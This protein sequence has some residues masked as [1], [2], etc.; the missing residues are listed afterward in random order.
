MGKLFGTFAKAR[1]ILEL[2]A[3]NIIN[4]ARIT[5]SATQRAEKKFTAKRKRESFWPPKT[6]PSRLLQSKSEGAIVT[7]VHGSKSSGPINQIN[8][9]GLLVPPSLRDARVE[10]KHAVD[11]SP[12]TAQ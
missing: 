8:L 7:G 1:G 12:A 11:R 2:D 9:S 6:K 5:H 4:I 10:G 3:W